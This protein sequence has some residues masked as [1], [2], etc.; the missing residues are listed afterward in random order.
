M[1]LS[2]GVSILGAAST[3]VG[4]GYAA[5]TYYQE[6]NALRKLDAQRA[7]L[8][9]GVR[10]DTTTVGASIVGTHTGSG[11]ESNSSV[12]AG[13]GIAAP[14]A[15]VGAERDVSREPV[16]GYDYMWTGMK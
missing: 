13:A 14:S 9:M 12:G 15:G 7:D 10:A 5:G 4:T 1:S 3:L 2:D 11:A 6:R 16:R 8:E